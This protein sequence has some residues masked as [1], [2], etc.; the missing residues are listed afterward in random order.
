MRKPPVH[1]PLL[2]IHVHFDKFIYEVM[3]YFL[4]L[5]ISEW[6]SECDKTNNC[7]DALLQKVKNVFTPA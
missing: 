3:R 5:N 1:F 4:L 7:I 6:T 2:K